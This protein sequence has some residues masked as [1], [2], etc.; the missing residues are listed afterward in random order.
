MSQ[1]QTISSGETPNRLALRELIEAYSHC[2]E[3]RAAQR[4]D[5]SP[6]RRHLLRGV[7]ERQDPKPSSE[8]LFAERPLYVEWLEG[9]ALS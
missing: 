3:R 5:V 4:S 6:Y 9:R 8:W 1:H 2:A 7:H